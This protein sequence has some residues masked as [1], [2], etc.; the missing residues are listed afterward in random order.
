MPPL[1]RPTTQLDVV[2]S[3]NNGADVSP[4]YTLTVY[5]DLSFNGV[6]FTADNV[7]VRVVTTSF[8]I[9]PTFVWNVGIFKDIWI[10]G[11]NGHL[12]E[13]GSALQC[14]VGSSISP[15]A[16]TVINSTTATCRVLSTWLQS[17]LETT[18]TFGYA[19]SR[20]PL[21]TFPFTF[22]APMTITSMAPWFGP[23]GAAVTMILAKPL[24]LRMQE[25]VG[26]TF[27]NLY[28]RG[29]VVN[30]SVV[31]CVV[32]MT[33]SPT[34]S[35]PV[36]LVVDN[37]LAS[38]TPVYF[39]YIVP[40]TMLDI[41]VVQRNQT[42]VVVRTTGPLLP[43]LSCL[44]G[45]DLITPATT[46]MDSLE[47]ECM[48]PPASSS[49]SGSMQVQLLY[50]MMP[51]AVNT[52]TYQPLPPAQVTA[53]TPNVGFIQANTTIV[54]QGSGLSVPLVCQFTC[55]PADSPFSTSTA[56]LLSSSMAQ[57]VAPSLPSPAL[58]GCS[59]LQ[60]VVLESHTVLWSYMF[61]YID[62]SMLQIPP[63]VGRPTLQLNAPFVVDAK[64][65]LV[66]PP[67]LNLIACS[68]DD[69]SDLGSS[70]VVTPAISATRLSCH[71]PRG[72]IGVG[73]VR[74][75]WQEYAIFTTDIE[76]IPP[77]RVDSYSPS[78]GATTGGTRLRIRGQRFHPALPV[79]CRFGG[80]LAVNA[81]YM[82]ESLVECVTPPRAQ[83]NQTNMDVLVGRQVVSLQPG[84]TYLD[85]PTLVK[86]IGGSS[87]VSV[88]VS[89]NWRA[90]EPFGVYCNIANITTFGEWTKNSTSV[91]CDGGGPSSVALSWN[92][93]EWSE[94]LPIYVSSSVTSLW[95]MKVFARQAPQLIKVAGQGLF[96]AS[97]CVVGTKRRVVVNATDDIVFCL[98]HSDDLGDNAVSVSVSVNNGQ[99]VLASNL[100]VAVL[101]APTLE[102]I[103]PAFGSVLGGTL[104]HMWGSNLPRHDDVGEIW[105]YVSSATAGWPRNVSSVTCHADNRLVQGRWFVGM[106]RVTCPVSVSVHR[107]GLSLNGVDVSNVVLV[108]DNLLVLVD[109]VPRMGS[110]AGGLVSLISTAFNTSR[111]YGCVVDRQ[112]RVDL[113]VINATHGQCMLPSFDGSDTTTHSISYFENQ[114]DD[115]DS[116]PQSNTLVYWVVQPPQV[117]SI[118]PVL[119][120]QSTL[121][122]VAL[123]GRNFIDSP[124]YHCRIGNTSLPASWISPTQ[125][126]CMIAVELHANEYSVGLL[127][128]ADASN[129]LV[130][131]PLKLTIL[132]DPEIAFITPTHGNEL[133]TITIVGSSFPQ[134]V[135]CAMD[136][137]FVQPTF[138][139][140]TMVVCAVPPLLSIPS[141]LK[142]SLAVNGHT[143]LASVL[144]SAESPPAIL[145]VFPATI[146]STWTSPFQLM[147][148]FTNTTLQVQCRFE[149]TSWPLV[150]TTMGTIGNQS[151]LAFCPPP[152]VS[153][154]LRIALSVSTNGQAFSNRR[155]VSIVSPATLASVQP[156]TV[157]FGP[158]ST[159]A[160]V[161]VL[162]YNMPTECTCE[163]RLAGQAVAVSS[164]ATW[165]SSF[166]VNCIVP[167][168][169]GV[170][171]Y[172]ITLVYQ[173]LPLAQN[174]LR[175]E[176]A[177]VPTVIQVYPTATATLQNS[178]MT[179][180][181]S[182][183]SAN[184]RFMCSFGDKF[185]Q[186]VRTNSTML[187]C[188]IP[189]TAVPNVVAF[190]L[191]GND[192]V[193]LVNQSFTYFATPQVLEI[194]PSI[195]HP[196]TTCDTVDIRGF[197]LVPIRTC[198]WMAQPTTPTVVVTRALYVNSTLVQ[199][200]LDTV[201]ATG[202]YNVYV[203][204][205]GHDLS[206]VG[207]VQ[208]VPAL[209]LTSM[210]PSFGMT[211]Q[212]E[213]VLFGSTFSP[214]ETVWCY[215][216]LIH[217]EAIVVNSTALR[218][219]LQLSPAQI[220]T[221]H[222]VYVAATTNQVDY[223]NALPFQFA[224]EFYVRAAMPATGT[225]AGQSEVYIVGLVNASSGLECI[226]PSSLVTTDLT[227]DVWFQTSKV[228]ASVGVVLDSATDVLLSGSYF[229]QEPRVQLFG[230]GLHTHL[231]CDFG[232]SVVGVENVSPYVIQCTLPRPTTPT[233][234]LVVRAGQSLIVLRSY[235][236]PRA[237]P[238]VV[239][240]VLPNFTSSFMLVNADS[241]TVEIVGTHFQP[242]ASA[243]CVV[244]S[245]PTEWDVA[246]STN[247]GRQFVSFP[248][249][250]FAMIPAEAEIVDV[251][252]LIGYENKSTRITV[253]GYSLDTLET[254]TAASSSTVQCLF[255]TVASA[256][257]VASPT[258]LHCMAPRQAPGL[259]TLS[260]VPATMFRQLKSFTFQ[261]I[262]R[263]VLV[264]VQPT[265][266]SGG[267]LVTVTM[268]VIPFTPTLSCQFDVDMVPAMYVN[269]TTILCQAPRYHSAGRVALRV[270]LD[271][272]NEVMPST[273]ASATFEFRPT[274]VVSSV[275]PDYMLDKADTI[276]TVHGFNL[277]V[278][279]SCVFACI[280]SSNQ[281][282]LV[283]INTTVISPTEVQCAVKKYGR[284]WPTDVSLYVSTL[285]S[286]HSNAISIKVLH[287]VQPQRWTLSPKSGSI[288]GGYS[289]QITGAHF[290][291]LTVTCWIGTVQARGMWVSSHLVT[292]RLPAAPDTSLRQVTL[293][294][295]EI[296]IPTPLDFQYT[297]NAVV[298]SCTPSTGIANV[299]T[300]IDVAGMHFAFS[301]DVQCQFDLVS[302]PAIHLSSTSLRCLTPP[303]HVE[304]TATFQVVSG[305]DVLWTSTFTFIPMPTLH[306]PPYPLVGWPS[307]TV[308]LMGSHLMAVAYCQFG[309]ATIVPVQTK[310]STHVT[311]MVPNNTLGMMST[312][313]VSVRVTADELLPTTPLPF[314]Y[315]RPMSIT[316]LAVLSSHVLDVIGHFYDALDRVDCVF[317]LAGNTTGTVVSSTRLKCPIPDRQSTTGELATTP[318]SVV[319][320]SCNEI[321][322]TPPLP[323]NV[324]FTFPKP[325]R[326][327][328]L[329]PDRGSV[330]G[331]TLVRVFF[332]SVPS[333]TTSVKCIFGSQY[334]LGSYEADSRSVVCVA[335]RG[336]PNESVD[337]SLVVDTALIETMLK[338]QYVVVPVVLSIA[339]NWINQMDLQLR[340]TVRPPLSSNA[341]V[342]LRANGGVPCRGVVLSKTEVSCALTNV[343]FHTT[344][345]TDEWTMELSVNGVDFE[346]L[347]THVYIRPER[348]Q[349]FEITPA[350]AMVN[351]SQQVMVTGRGFE[352]CHQQHSGAFCTCA[353]GKVSTVAQYISRTV[354]TCD[355]PR[356]F[357]GEAVPFAL[358]ANGTIV[359]TSGSAGLTFAVVHSTVDSLYPL[360]GLARGGAVIN[361][362]GYDLDPRLGCWFDDKIFVPATVLN[363][364]WLQCVVPARRT[365]STVSLAIV[366]SLDRQQI[367]PAV[368]FTYVDT[369]IVTQMSPPAISDMGSRTV[370][371]VVQSFVAGMDWSCRFETSSGHNFAAPGVWYA[372]NSTFACNVPN[373]KASTAVLVH[374]V[375]NGN[376]I[377]GTGWQ[378]DILA[379]N[380]L[381]SVVP[382]LIPREIGVPI[383]VQTTFV[384]PPSVSL[385]CNFIG[386]NTTAYTVPALAVSTTSVACDSPQFALAGTAT[387]T[388]GMYG[389]AYSTN[390]LSMYVYDRPLGVSVLPAFGPIGGNVS[391]RVLGTNFL[392][393]SDLACRFGTSIAVLGR[394]ISSN[395]LHC[396]A[397]PSIIAGMVDVSVTLNG[398]YFDPLSLQY[399]YLPEWHIHTVTPSNAPIS[400]GTAIQILLASAT[401][402]NESVSCSFEHGGIV[403]A[404]TL[405]NNTIECVTPPFDHPTSVRLGL[406][407]SSSGLMLAQSTTVIEFVLPIQIQSTAPT[408]GIERTKLA[409]HI[410]GYNF[411]PTVQCRVKHT[412]IEGGAMLM[413]PFHVR[414]VIPAK[415]AQDV[416]T[417][418]VTNNAID[419]ALAAT[420]HFYPPLIA[421]KVSP[422][423]GPVTGG[424]PI[425]LYGANM[426]LV[427]LCRFDRILMPATHIQPN[428]I[429]CTTPP[430][431]AGVIEVALSGNHRDFT[432]ALVGFEF[433]LVP[434]VSLVLPLQGQVNSLVQVTG[435]GFVSSAWCR[436]HSEMVEAQVLS[437]TALTCMAPPLVLPVVNGKVQTKVPVE[438]SL[439]EGHDWS[440][441]QVMFEYV[442]PFSVRRVSPVVGSESGQTAVHL[443]GRGFQPSKRY[444]CYFDTSDVLAIFVTAKQLVCKTPAHLPGT[445][446]LIL[447]DEQANT[448][449]IPFVFRYTPAI[450]LHD[451]TPSIASSNGGDTVWLVGLHFYFSF[452][453]ACHFDSTV[454]PAVFYNATAVSCVTP[455][456]ISGDV[457]LGWSANGVDVEPS[458]SILFTFV[459]PPV[460]AAVSKVSSALGDVVQVT[461]RHITPQTV[462]WID[463]YE[464]RSV[465][466]STNAIN[467]TVP[468]LENR[469]TV[470]TLQ[471][472]RD[473]SVRSNVARLL[474]M[475][476]AIVR[477]VVPPFGSTHG[478]TPLRILG[479][480]F[481][482]SLHLACVFSAN[483]TSAELDRTVATFVSPY[484][485]HCLSPPTPE[486]QAMQVAVFQ[487][488]VAVSS[489]S[490]SFRTIPFAQVYQVTPDHA[491]HRGGQS[492]VVRGAHFVQSSALRC[493]FGTELVPAAYVNSTCVRCIAPAHETGS[494]A[495][496]MSNNNVDVEAAD[497]GV[498]FTFVQ[499]LF[500]HSISPASGSVVGNTTIAIT[501]SGF[502]P[503]LTC[504]FG[505]VSVVAVVTSN[506]SAVC[507]SPP[508][509]KDFKSTSVM[510]GVSVGSQPP[511]V[512]VEYTY[513]VTNRVERLTPS[514]AFSVGGT[515][516]MIQM[517]RATQN[518]SCWF[519]NQL[520]IAATSVSSTQ[521]ACVT[522][523][524]P[525]GIVNLTVTSGTHGSM[526][527]LPFD[528]V[529]TP[530]VLNVAKP[531]TSP[532]NGGSDIEV[533][534][535]HVEFVRQCL[536]GG[537]EP[538]PAYVVDHSVHC[539][540]PPQLDPGSY[541]LVLL[542]PYGSIDT[543]FRVQYADDIAV[544][545]AEGFP[546]ESTRPE[547]LQV[548]PDTVETSGGS[549]LRIRGRG[550]QNS[551]FLAC[552]FG[553]DSVPATYLS[554]TLLTCVA[555]RHVPATVVLEVTCDGVTFS[556]SGTEIQ[557][558]HD[559]VV[560]QLS[561]G[562]GTPH[563]NTLVTIQGGH[564]LPNAPH[565]VCRFGPVRVPATYVSSNVIQCATPPQEDT[566]ANVV[567]VHVSNNNASFTSHGL[568][569]TYSPTPWISSIW[570]MRATQIGGTIVTVRGYH[571][572]PRQVFCVWNVLPQ[573][574]SLAQV[575]T[576]TLLRCA[577]P[578]NLSVGPLTLQLTTNNQDLS[579][580]V[581]LVI[582]PNVVL[583]KLVPS[584]G[585]ALRGR[586]LVHVVG[587]GFENQVELSCRF[588]TARVA[589]TFINS[590]LIQ[591]ESPPHSVGTIPL[592]VTWNGVDEAVDAL[593]FQFVDDLEVSVL[594]PLHSLV[595]G[596]RPVFVK[597]LN[598]LNSSSLAC[599]FG[600]LM[601]PATF[602]S[603]T[604][605]VC[606]VPS[607]VGNLVDPVGLVSFDVTC[608]GVDFTSSGLQF[609][610]LGACPALRYCTDHDIALVPN[611]TFP[612]SDGRNFSQC[613]PSTF[614]PRAGQ[615]SC[616]PCPVGFYC[617]DF[618]LS[619]PILCPA[620]F[621]CDRHALRTP[622]T[623]CPEGHYC[624]PGTKS[625]NV[626]D[627][628]NRSDYVV[629]S[630]TG[631]TTFDVTSRSWSIV[632]RPS[633]A[634]GSRR[635]EQPPNF[636]DPQC[637]TRQCDFNTSNLLAEKP[638][639][640]PLGTF[641]R[642]G[643][644]TPSMQLQNF[645]SPQPCFRG[646]FCPR[647]STSPEGQGPCPS[648]YYCPTITDAI[649][650]PRGSYCPGV[651]N[652][653]PI[654]CYPGSYQPLDAQPMCQLCPVG[655][656]CPG[657]NRTAPELCP[658][659]FVC[660]SWGLSVPVVTCPS[661]FYCN[662]G[663]WSSD[664]AELTQ[665]RPIPCSRGTFCYAGVKQDLTIDWLPIAPEGATAKQ[666][667]TEG[668]FCP[669]GTVASTLCYPGHYCPP[670]TQFPLQV[671][672]GTF[673]QRE[674]SIAPTLCFP[675]TFSTFKASTECRICPAGYACAG[676]GV[677]IP[678]ICAAGYYRSSIPCPSGYVCGE[679]TTRERQ[680]FHMC[681]G[682]Y[683]CGTETTQPKQFDHICASGNVCYRGTKDTEST[684]F[685]CPQGSFCPAGTADP[686]VKETQCP[687]GTSS[688][689]VS[690]ELT[691]CSIL[692]VAVCDKSPVDTSYYP[693][694][695]YVFQGTTYQY[696]SQTNIGRTPEIQ[697]LKKILPVNLSASAAPWVNDTIDVIRSCPTV[698][699][700]VGG[701]LVTIVGR[702]FLPSNR[703]TCEFQ[704][705][706]GD[707]VF[708][709]VPAAYVN[710]TRVTCRTPPFTFV[711]D[712]SQLE[713]D[714][715]VYVTNFGVHRSATGASILY[716]SNPI[717]VDMD[718]GY[719][720]DEEGPRPKALGWFALRAFS[721]A[722]LSFDLRAIPA[723]MVYDEH[724]KI[725]LYVTPS[726]CQDE[727]C[728][729]RGIL[730]PPGDDTET[731][732]CRQPI[733]LPSWITSSDFEQRTV[734]NLTVMALEDMLIKP[735]IHLLYGLFLAAEDFFVNTT[736]VDITS[737]ARANVTQG[738]VADSRPLSSVISFEERLV[739]REYTF[740]AI[741]R[742]EYSLVTPVPLNLPPRFDQFERG[743]VL[744]KANVSVGSDQPNLRDIPTPL[745]LNY[746][747][748]PYD[749]LETTVAKTAKYRE[750]FQG[751]SAAHDTYAMEQVVLPYLPFFSHCRTYDSYIPIYDL[752]E[753]PVECQL[754]G[755]E[756][757]DRNWWR[758]T[759]P[760]IPNQDDI[761]V[762]APTDVLEEPVADYCYRQLQCNYE[763][764]LASV[765]V[766]P[767]WYE[768]KDLTHL[769][770]M[771]NEP[772]MYAQYL[773]GGDLYNTL[774]AA[775]N[776]D[777]FVPVLVDR[778]AAERIE[779]GCLLQCYPRSV[780]LQLMYYQVTSELKRLV[781]ATLVFDEFDNDASV[782]DYTLK[783]EYAPLN[784]IE[785][786]I[787]FAFDLNVFMVLFSCIGFTCTAIASVFW[788]ITRLTTR[789]RDPPKLRY[790]SYLALIAPPP[791][792][793]IVL[794]SVPCATVI[795]AFY[796]LL[797]GDVFG[798]Y[799]ANAYPWSPWGSEF[800][801]LD[802]MKNHYMALQV[803]PTMVQTLRH[804]RVGLC[805]FILAIFLLCEGVMIFIPRTISI[806]E[807]AAE[808]KGG[809]DESLWKP[810]PWRRANVILTCAVVSLFLVMVIEYSF[811]TDFGA[812]IFYTQLSFELVVPTVIMVVD[813][814]V[815]DSLLYAPIVC[816]I[817][818]I[819]AMVLM[820]APDFLGFVIASF[821]AFG[822]VLV[823]RVYMK[824]T[825]H[826]I[827]QTL[828]ETAAAS[829]GLAK[830]ATTMMRFYLGRKPKKPPVADGKS[831]DAT[832]KEDDPL[833]PKVDTDDGGGATVEPIIDCCMEY[834]MTTLAMF[835][836][837]IVIALLMVFRAETSM[838][839][840][841]S[842]RHQDMEY[843]F[844]YFTLL[845]PF[846]LLADVFILHVI[847]LF[848]GWKLYDYFVYCRYRFIQREHRWKGM[849]HN[850]DE[851][852]EQGVRHLDQMCFSSQYYFMCA[853]QTWGMLSL[854]LAIEIMVRNQYN[855]FGDP[856]AIYLIPFMLS[857]CIFT[858]NMCLYISRKFA[859]YKL[860]HEN[861]AW[862]NAPDDDD[863]GVPDWEEL[864]R[865]KGAS[866]E[867]FLMNQRLTSETFR[868]KFL[869]YNRPWIVAQLPN[870]LTPRTL[871][872]ARPYLITQFSKI[873]SSLNP[874]VS[875]DDDDDGKPHFG[876]VSLNAPSRDL[877]RLWLAKA[878]RRLRL[879]L[880]VQ[881]LIN[882][883]R[884]VECE[885][886]LSRR[887]LQ[888]EMVI[889]IEVMGDKFERS[890]PSDEFDVA[891]WKKYFAQHQKFKT[892]C[893]SCLAKQK[894]EM[895]M[896]A[897]G[898]TGDHADDDEAAATLGFGQVYLTAASR[899]LMLKWYRLGQDRVFGKTGKRRAVANVS[900]DDDD[901]ATRGAV[902]ANRPVR[903]NA[904]STAV[905]LKWM[906]SARL[907]LK[908]KVQGK[909]VTPLETSAKPKRKKPPTKETIKAQR[910][911]RK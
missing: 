480:N 199:C 680:Y 316:S 631:I 12:D 668:T 86:A 792:I 377:I 113:V 662:E 193:V 314:T 851:C 320:N 21:G 615:P 810:T 640:C 522:P 208:V 299:P 141:I 287:A 292:C 19:G 450:T 572:T 385:Q 884:K 591:C 832:K 769:F 568:F 605:L 270:F 599:R 633:P 857:V 302:T 612:A 469:P 249:F 38:W 365:T 132:P 803:D 871:R 663:T 641:C 683:L 826:A 598:F 170:N 180:V 301:Q 431:A 748:L 11:P 508:A 319:W 63:V 108:R 165:V 263:P 80:S 383:V 474:Y 222:V 384:I 776:S 713:A 842:I 447:A 5:V 614:Q 622:E 696:N 313:S 298:Q 767:R 483:A 259:V 838:S 359:P 463:G 334:T 467:C 607:R 4:V 185:V 191:T 852:I 863:S 646:F 718:C 31:T 853:I 839:D 318:F 603:P 367:S 176:L 526:D 486:P 330:D 388:L 650:C 128:A 770:D 46:R 710:S 784:Y 64:W 342:W 3:P 245:T 36:S 121:T 34:T 616:L 565:L 761:R 393:S 290:P 530:K 216:D 532:L 251:W 131:Q 357:V 402:F 311:C 306:R 893:L 283:Q 749:T 791:T 203:L 610:Y 750:T 874:N 140:Q 336:T 248:T 806:S 639:V 374:L 460:I 399:E 807:R 32:P 777:I 215:Y 129:F 23:G 708:M 391:V 415:L 628:Q 184:T 550:F 238:P 685:N 672:L 322:T 60:V 729:G 697:I 169:L 45:H 844:F 317:G 394:Y 910:T 501:G 606:I 98:V 843:Y 699:P 446:A 740:V 846:R 154:S 727:Q 266:G 443:Y 428:E 403:P 634:T 900:D 122:T 742:H 74:V 621:V 344:H 808:D 239:Q 739:P 198:H 325:V 235:E 262:V 65:A 8:S 837:P 189:S 511:L 489:T 478:R 674:G 329:A 689:P 567:L 1:V 364:T 879:R 396:V 66:V 97:H 382:T 406:Q 349:V 502:G 348:M 143:S 794:A 355:A 363:S 709:S 242:L 205:N 772:V 644:S 240:A 284:S 274:P 116:A 358:I 579:T 69:F 93:Q 79:Q 854:I 601:S 781:S 578:R 867:A 410:Y 495:F 580:G 247:E 571:F 124:M 653:K 94:R 308:Q 145:Q 279:T 323:T 724:Y 573:R 617:P 847:E 745:P 135:M 787:H 717:T 223:S 575:V 233:T 827:V 30:G 466:V 534:G 437:S 155:S 519:G 26:C 395:E 300:F 889:P 505:D 737:P 516:L 523:S 577:T 654:A 174:A 445:V 264:S 547:L 441:N 828:K 861:T 197:D 488:D 335:P 679:A 512:F 39:T 109:I 693:V 643:V 196:T 704:L 405:S 55:Y 381:M 833:P 585:P 881:P 6:D 295:G 876:P 880:A 818:V 372:E 509:Q 167:P 789:I 236:L 860:R 682:G 2:F 453:M 492:I 265:V 449:S 229:V 485:L 92:T 531:T 648:G 563:G 673:S 623:M 362:R 600:E 104:L 268:S 904:A 681:P 218:C 882:A 386:P 778:T 766:N 159:S 138:V 214:R 496:G 655:Y 186:V 595:T 333:T 470:G 267:T 812:N 161:S 564:F 244:N 24:S 112:V 714:V 47:V 228:A 667:C 820:A 788:L 570:P 96:S 744:I 254:L 773:Q 566:A 440:F 321:P 91:R 452:A 157:I 107:V 632:P 645:S 848:R 421:V 527:M 533:L 213:V 732:P 202:T 537:A 221:H 211:W 588:G 341:T 569:F 281:S 253:E 207:T 111:S 482:R 304:G 78:I 751:L 461:G 829:K 368:N 50:E 119:A 722:F 22:V 899:A 392:P 790:L 752:L 723:D 390:A 435:S 61:R 822:L 68:F 400:G 188:L 618:G 163:F 911:K 41:I 499:P 101:P 746:W 759:F 763:E 376:E 771:L 783:V 282:V 243:Y 414:C 611:G 105:V 171:T 52:L 574:T 88:Q 250:V 494:V 520:P 898:S 77:A 340:A 596:Q 576:A 183:F 153:P 114:A 811:W 25:A 830:Q 432:P 10:T 620:G 476:P 173:G 200:N 33:D 678:A 497:D 688:Q 444:T 613:P 909:K 351:T 42:I 798:D 420:V 150:K 656:I 804:G 908:A 552:Q 411:R 866:H 102:A 800:W 736:Q 462:C 479:Q 275:W 451:V 801:G 120:F 493:A 285:E 630:E 99:I 360:S 629:N 278:N 593:P 903:L 261:Y 906:V 234:T 706:G 504:W 354:L 559:A 814:C 758:R 824:P 459:D 779:G 404:R 142:I 296:T 144:F 840:N 125:L 353:F 194:V 43:N 84:F 277:D 878:R 831:A 845:I 136:Q 147:G 490:G 799:K 905:A 117:D 558:V 703:L 456:H 741:Y 887:Q 373:I 584:I 583:T 518:V 768:A 71:V 76:V 252:P 49:V 856:A 419:F 418:D 465:V 288:Q 412:I 439:N 521:F 608:N 427:S 409:V 725:A 877:I 721:Q 397:P 89:L 424:T 747:K 448:H 257:V 544:V 369:P 883:A 7:I 590:T 477:N 146:A 54:L 731:S 160:F 658:A 581:N 407:T 506:A 331:G 651:G 434:Q 172:A 17:D 885:S 442:R 817:N 659:G 540:S 691:D 429:E 324:T 538:V 870:I 625:T 886:C 869:N 158:N 83:L 433:Q 756:V 797:N 712:S 273:S 139:N 413:S 133:T 515:T 438:V 206:R 276:L 701:T 802:N 123:L 513:V 187:S 73:V 695:S 858:R 728:D 815:S 416:A 875:D 350:Y 626:L 72:A 864:E 698:V 907:N 328:K 894:L 705:L 426:H 219:H 310:R 619:K 149:S 785:L 677:Y 702:N 670:G 82:N 156:S 315:I 370:S 775:A 291:M 543:T 130:P 472:I 70:V 271:S 529:P 753:S 586:T 582:T 256:A 312:S 896:P 230:V 872:R 774:L 289:I 715:M 9:A 657:F 20:L 528:F 711:A 347:P 62:Q 548:F 192:V 297:A 541:P 398:L 780:T 425:R 471:L 231:V 224:P 423:N 422:H 757:F 210:V 75:L 684:R 85:P 178:S 134:L 514:Q 720:D 255:G 868:F 524:A 549:V 337:V 556:L 892:L 503:T 661:G 227:V 118:D 850:L 455:P 272:E 294:F 539:I 168:S 269:S 260:I 81:Q 834:T 201:L 764:D 821:T 51:Y 28:A 517:T 56:L 836:Q 226:V 500:V 475:L 760:P 151:T 204:W 636:V 813:A 690:N 755:L 127:F 551:R 555:P 408:A 181:G 103:E 694:F 660:S 642:S 823:R 700:S 719:N 546:D 592:H 15:V 557:V 417:L 849:E 90:Q 635:L 343:V 87:I 793:G 765:D 692:P 241:T 888:V 220:K 389:Q 307:S 332:A 782:S 40:P 638:F 345:P 895:R 356:A 730:K 835:F 53:A 305:L 371:L 687:L 379:S 589:A 327:S 562:H 671:P 209:H 859:M 754:P 387:L 675:G 13:A 458:G 346:A 258:E 491:L 809:D 16:A 796:L 473:T 58:T 624:L 762:V 430:H 602:I 293:Q 733:V 339:V 166:K 35:V 481:N 665:L 44:F 48:A 280:S 454:I 865:I 378:V 110:V 609:E 177:P 510:L 164:S 18:L 676:Y 401:S 666:T 352:L 152:K 106:N 825:F 507:V 148:V 686:G 361:V 436:F 366:L 536:V 819:F 816:V 225:V 637:L 855:M 217:V 795:G 464:T 37:Q 649:A 498:Q 27:G 326:V 338:Y 468:P 738:I 726:I 587:S 554:S 553:Y 652:V 487:Y 873:L 841:W 67:A 484:E 545:V 286:I 902:W 897:L 115:G 786:V 735:E 14:Q 743:R 309:D 525:V 95:P 664:P 669:E 805:F 716:T 375:L 647:G 560:T 604:L 597:G 862:H 232:G 175:V 561:P 179:I 100:T 627:F 162:G 195:L 594:T 237:V 137:A 707:L 59:V 535:F 457:T 212:S 734:V 380:T 542:S 891:E 126:N 190:T 901:V 303:R 246:L 182:A 57:C 29:Q 890:F